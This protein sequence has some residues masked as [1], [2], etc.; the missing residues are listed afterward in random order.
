MGDIQAN[1]PIG[2]C[3][4]NV[5][6]VSQDANSMLQL[7][8]LDIGFCRTNHE[9]TIRNDVIVGRTLTMLPLGTLYRTTSVCTSEMLI[10]SPK[11]RVSPTICT[12]V[13]TIMQAVS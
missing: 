6:V 10:V 11:T 8:K 2:N 3:F 7:L 9:P 5:V 12:S 13:F 4:T 1:A